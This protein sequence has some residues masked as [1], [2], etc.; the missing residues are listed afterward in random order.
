M[1]P[2]RQVVEQAI[3]DLREHQQ[4]LKIM[5]KQYTSSV[6]DPEVENLMAELYYE[7]VNIANRLFVVTQSSGIQLPSPNSRYYDPNPSP[8]FNVEDFQDFRRNKPLSYPVIIG[9]LTKYLHHVDYTI[10]TVD[11]FIEQ[12]ER[13]LKRRKDLQESNLFQLTEAKLKQMI[14]EAMV[15]S[16]SKRITFRDAIADPEVHPKIKDLLSNENEADFNQGIE[17]LAS[18][19]ADKYDVDDPGFT[20]ELRLNKAFEQFYRDN[21]GY[22]IGRLL[23]ARDQYDVGM[24]F[25][26]NSARLR[27]NDLKQIK[28]FHQFLN[29]Q[30]FKTSEIKK[31]TYVY[32]FELI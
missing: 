3:A 7:R 21:K 24:G 22:F 26:V 10:L 16:R 27:N 17:M 4:A 31:G 11:R 29:E 8:V 13:K 14:L 23:Q 12:L 5:S 9:N 25:V 30:G 2:K 19:Y 20:M 28:L 1:N 15:F 32:Y 6:Y 18:L